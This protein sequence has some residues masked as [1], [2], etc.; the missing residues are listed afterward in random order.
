MANCPNVKCN[1][2][3]DP[4]VYYCIDCGAAIPPE[5]RRAARHEAEMA[6]ISEETAGATIERGVAVERGDDGRIYAT[7]KTAYNTGVGTAA[8][9][10]SSS[11]GATWTEY[12]T[13]S[14]RQVN[15]APTPIRVAEPAWLPTDLSLDEIQQASE[16]LRT[17]MERMGTIALSNSE[18][19]SIGEA[20]EE[21]AP[22]K[23]D[24]SQ[25][26]KK[27]MAEKAE[28]AREMQRQRDRSA[29]PGWSFKKNRQG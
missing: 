19:V 24:L 23:A 1:T 9:Y 3:I 28:R 18:I 7:P 17:A 25:V 12:R 6:A 26:V 14:S 13:V 10:T 22:T 4:G 20:L 27:A 2:E 21:P 29:S 16:E 15:Q 8:S 11:S 5:L